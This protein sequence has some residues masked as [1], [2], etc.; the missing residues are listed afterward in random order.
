MYQHWDKTHKYNF[1]LKMKK[2]ELR[3]TIK[4]TLKHIKKQQKIK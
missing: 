1:F 4:N 2:E 3:E